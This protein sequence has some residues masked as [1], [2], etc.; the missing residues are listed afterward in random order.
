[1]TQYYVIEIQGYDNN[2]FAYLVHAI[3]DADSVQARNKAESKY[4]QVLS[5]AAVS[6][7]PLHSVSLLY[8][9][10]SCVMYRSYNHNAEPEPEE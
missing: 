9:N 8:Q 3:S 7:L 5:A 1:M 10:G 6:N 2:T 4:F